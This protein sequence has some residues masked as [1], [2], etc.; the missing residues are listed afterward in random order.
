MR[1]KSWNSKRPH[2]TIQCSSKCCNNT[3]NTTWF[4]TR[5]NH[6]SRR[7]NR[8][9]QS[10]RE[11]TNIKHN[12]ELC[13]RGGS[14]RENEARLFWCSCILKWDSKPTWWIVF[15][16]SLT[17]NICLLNF[18]SSGWWILI[19]DAIILLSKQNEDGLGSLNS[20]NFKYM[21]SKVWM[22]KCCERWRN[23]SADDILTEKFFWLP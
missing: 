20:D 14:R 2:V 17:S 21:V 15:L 5:N 6:Q 1:L 16:R 19:D 18:L 23:Y 11:M 9:A 13:I 7:A 22:K 12:F 8:V 3:Q 10:Y 4:T